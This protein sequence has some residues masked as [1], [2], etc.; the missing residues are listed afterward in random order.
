[1]NWN[2]FKNWNQFRNNSYLEDLQNM[3]RERIQE[4]Y[5]ENEMKFWAIQDALFSLKER[6]EEIMAQDPA[7]IPAYL[8]KQHDEICEGVDI[9]FTD[10]YEVV[11]WLKSSPVEVII[12]NER[13]NVILNYIEALIS[14]RYNQ[15][16]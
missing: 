14:L 3:V 15:D 10:I 1:M 5:E 7:E 11:A 8:R 13:A 16:A 2:D 6:I 9:D 4:K 12:C